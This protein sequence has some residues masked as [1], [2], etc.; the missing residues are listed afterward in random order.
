MPRTEAKKNRTKNTRRSTLGP[1]DGDGA[2]DDDHTICLMC[3][4]RDPADTEKA[5]VVLWV[6]CQLCTGWSHQV[7]VKYKPPTSE[8][9]GESSREDPFI[10]FDCKRSFGV[11]QWCRN[12][13]DGKIDGLM[14]EIEEIKKFFESEIT[15]LSEVV[16]ANAQ[17]IAEIKGR[18]ARGADPVIAQRV[19]SI[20][21]EASRRECLQIVTLSGIP[22]LNGMNDIAVVVRIADFL[23]LGLDRN[24]IIRC[25]RAKV[26]DA[27]RVPLMYCKFV[28]LRSRNI[29][30][31]ACMRNKNILLDNIKSGEPKT[32]VYVNEMLSLTAFKTLLKAKDL[33]KE[34][35]I[36]RVYTVDGYVFVKMGGQAVGKKVLT[37]AE[38]E[39]LISGDDGG[40][41][42]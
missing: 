38:L 4:Q 42:Q 18:E 32:K 19:S 2:G 6:E 21:E 31:H 26:N 28:D 1:A 16:Q 12:H 8:Q 40:G 24:D 22:I 33:V 35:R 25:W 23:E 17:E 29:F 37:V 15:S 9:E 5:A 13:V 11:K 10:C 3:R 27:R 36:D 39:A 34:K 20:E 30:F 14:G 41:G 7:C